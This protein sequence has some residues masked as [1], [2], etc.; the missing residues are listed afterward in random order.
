MSADLG[1][2]GRISVTAFHTTHYF[3][4]AAAHSGMAQGLR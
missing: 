1:P 4:F 3:P 2:A